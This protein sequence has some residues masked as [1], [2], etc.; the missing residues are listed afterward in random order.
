M[1][2]GSAITGGFLSIDAGNIITIGFVVVGWIYSIGKITERI[3]GFERWRLDHM[4]EARKRDEMI[5]QLG[6]ISSKLDGLME[7]FMRRN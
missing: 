6:Q 4:V 1:S 7:E 2:L 5:A 3:N